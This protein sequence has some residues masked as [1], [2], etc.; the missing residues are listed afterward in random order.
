MTASE[1]VGNQWLGFAVLVI[2]IMREKVE[3]M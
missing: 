3:D 2:D 1:G